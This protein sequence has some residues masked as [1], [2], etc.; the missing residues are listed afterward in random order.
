MQRKPVPPAP[1]SL[2]AVG[3][4]RDATPLVP[5]PEDDCCRRLI[6]RAG[7][8]DRG[9][10]SAWLVFLSAV[11]VLVDDD[12]GY[13]RRGDVGVDDREALAAGFRANVFLGGDV[14]DALDDTPA[15]PRDVFDAVRE[16][17]PPWERAKRDNWQAFWT[18][19]VRRRLDWA[20]LFG[21]AVRV[22]DTPCYRRA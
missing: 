19:R 16:Q 7:V 13:A 17:V 1:S 14:V 15:Q 22:D 21:Q 20:A 5:K 12:A 6:E 18:G 4:V 9:T 3:D 2:A 10:A 11:G 8:E